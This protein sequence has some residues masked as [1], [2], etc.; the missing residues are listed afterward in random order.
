M[1]KQSKNYLERIKPNFELIRELKSQGKSERTMAEM[2]G[3]SYEMWKKYKKNFPEFKALGEEIGLKRKRYP[4][5]Q[6]PCLYCGALFNVRH[7]NID[8]VNRF[9]SKK[10][11]SL[12]YGAIKRENKERKNQIK[13]VK[14]LQ[15]EANKIASEVKKLK[16]QIDHLKKCEMC[17]EWI[18]GNNRKK[19][20]PTCSRKVDNLRGDKRIRRNG[21][22]D[23][24]I[25]LEKLYNRD[26]GICQ[27][28]N[29][30]IIFG[31]DT[32]ADYYPSIDHIKP[33]SKG[34]TH[35]W[36]NV[37]LACRK[38]NWLKGAKIS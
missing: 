13:K 5:E 25:T 1:K 26:L 35:T 9:C 4:K 22:P 21:K 15:R 33:L 29:R 36:D 7:N 38:C 11:S 32:N 27:I 37:Q 30:V 14:A 16:G 24:S 3:V 2:L 31:N 10:C 6:K 8:D 17:G 12:F 18:W 34:G 23:L 28:C 19:R 20:C